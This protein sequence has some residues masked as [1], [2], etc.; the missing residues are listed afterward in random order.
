M[1]QRELGELG[2]E[3]PVQTQTDRYGPMGSGSQVGLH[4]G[5]GSHKY[6]VKPEFMYV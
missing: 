6:F 2:W 3:S 1:G 4:Q 5:S